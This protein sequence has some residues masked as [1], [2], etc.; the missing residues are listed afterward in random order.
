MQLESKK[1]KFSSNQATFTNKIYFLY[2]SSHIPERC[3]TQAQSL[4]FPR[5]TRPQQQ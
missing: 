2:F 5:S 1:N 3:S 4:R